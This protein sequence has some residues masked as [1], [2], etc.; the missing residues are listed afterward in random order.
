VESF[1]NGEDIVLLQ[2]LT[3]FVHS[4][5][6]AVK[7]KDFDSLITPEEGVYPIHERDINESKEF[8]RVTLSYKGKQKVGVLQESDEE[9]LLELVNR[10]FKIKPKMISLPSGEVLTQQ[11]LEKLPQGSVLTI[12]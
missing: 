6:A 2:D 9:E 3:D 12:S 1:I 7:R 10:K 5:Y 4:Q 8:L 11:L